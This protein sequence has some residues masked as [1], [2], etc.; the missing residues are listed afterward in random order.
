MQ[1]PESGESKEK[2]N[3]RFF[4]FLFFKLWS[5]SYSNHHNFRWIFTITRKIKIEKIVQY[6]FHTIQHIAHL[7][8][9]WDQNWGRGARGVCISLVGTE[10]KAGLPITIARNLPSFDL[11][12]YVYQ[13]CVCKIAVQCTAIFHV[14]YWLDAWSLEQAWRVYS[15]HPTN[16]LLVGAWW[17]HLT[18]IFP[19]WKKLCCRTNWASIYFLWL[20]RNARFIQLSVFL[21]KAPTHRDIFSKCY[22]IKPKSDCIYH[23]PIDLETNGRP[24]GYKSIGKW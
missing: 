3:F 9:K 17:P 20:R 22:Q 6:I 5:F 15:V 13:Y 23:F 8:W 21:Y 14:Q 4:W 1:D 16:F 24:F 12:L 2:S 11:I 10:P 7:S 18:A 19:Y